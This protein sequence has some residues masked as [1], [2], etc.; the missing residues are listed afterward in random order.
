MQNAKKI[1]IT[2]ESREIFIMRTNGKS[3]VR[4][5]CSGCQ[6]EV[7]MLRLDEAVSLSGQNMRELICRV[8]SGLVHSIETASGHWLICGQSLGESL[9]EK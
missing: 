8:D 6:A 3:T 2:T 1:L 9:K 7:E 5:S 4:G